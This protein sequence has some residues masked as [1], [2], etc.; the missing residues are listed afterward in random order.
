MQTGAGVGLGVEVG[1]AAGG[2]VALGEGLLPCG[3][4]LLP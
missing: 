3:L 2:E 1:A 4:V